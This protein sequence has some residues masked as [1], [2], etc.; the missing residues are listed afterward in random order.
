MG[1]WLY[2]AFDFTNYRCYRFP[3]S[4]STSTQVQLLLRWQYCVAV[5]LLLYVIFAINYVLPLSYTHYSHCLCNVVY[6]IYVQLSEY[7]YHFVYSDIRHVL[8]WHNESII[9]ITISIIIAAILSWCVYVHVAIIIGIIM[10][11]IIIH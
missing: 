9:N 2:G 1:R 8:M 4:S 5:L 3:I 10:T 7:E 6:Y 11:I